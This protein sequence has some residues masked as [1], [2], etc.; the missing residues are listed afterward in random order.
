MPKTER[1][2]Y[3]RAP[4]IAAVVVGLA[5]AGFVYHMQTAPKEA[6]PM[7]G[8]CTDVPIVKYV[9]DGDRDGKFCAW[10]HKNYW[11][12]FDPNKQLW[13]CDMVNDPPPTPVPAEK[14]P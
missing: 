2:F 9:G 11:C 12:Q 14:K 10:N 5:I 4:I 8:T 13:W 3:L 6:M 1:P 7:R